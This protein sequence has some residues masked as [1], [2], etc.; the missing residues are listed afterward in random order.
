M[1]K[2]VWKNIITRFGVPWVLVSDNGL[3]FDSKVFREC[4][5]SLRLTNRYLLLAHP[6]SNEQAEATTSAEE[7]IPIEVSLSSMRV[8]DFVQSSNDERMVG[9]LDALEERREM[10][11]V[12]LADYQ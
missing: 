3:H 8:A 5:G 2:F 9:N 11:A 7:V 12:W 1:K 4:C 6:Q 10:V